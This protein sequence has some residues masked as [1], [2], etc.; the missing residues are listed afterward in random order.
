MADSRRVGE[1]L[2]AVLGLLVD[3][4]EQLAVQ[5]VPM[6]RATVFEVEAASGDLGKL[7]G[8]RGRTI[9][10]LRTLLDC[11]AEVDGAQYGLEL[12]ED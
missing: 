11:R 6:R 2:G 1:D 9:R 7:I 12:L 4:P 8:R 5:A 10:A 3:E